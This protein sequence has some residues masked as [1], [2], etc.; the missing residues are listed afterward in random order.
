LADCEALEYE[1]RKD[2]MRRWWQE[3]RRLWEEAIASARANSAVM[4]VLKE[5]SLL[6]DNE[7]ISALEI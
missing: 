1:I 5:Y 3:R 7:S 6:L 4:A 2:E